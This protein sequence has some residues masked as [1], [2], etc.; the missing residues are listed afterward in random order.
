[1]DDHKSVYTCTAYRKIFPVGVIFTGKED[2]FFFFFFRYNNILLQN[3]I[4]LDSRHSQF[5]FSP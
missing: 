5:L 1:M 3:K 2:K 4:G